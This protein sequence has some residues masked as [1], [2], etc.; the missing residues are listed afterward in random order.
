MLF[1]IQVLWVGMGFCAS[2]KLPGEV[3]SSKGPHE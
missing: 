3:V 2:D 1:L